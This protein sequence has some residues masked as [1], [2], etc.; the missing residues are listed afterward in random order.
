MYRCAKSL[1]LSVCAATALS[2]SAQAQ[3]QTHRPF[4]AQALRGDLVILQTPDISLNGHS[5]RLAPGAR[6]RGDT[7]LLQQPASLSGEKLVVHYTLDPSGLLMDV[8]VLNPVELA[9]KPWPRSQQEAENWSF[10]QASQ[11]WTKR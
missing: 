1:I 11:V 6:V 7:N 10:D 5:A 3:A 9:N 8:W 4:P 2:L